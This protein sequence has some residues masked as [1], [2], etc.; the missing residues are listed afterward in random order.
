MTSAAPPNAS[1]EPISKPRAFE[2]ARK[3]LSE[4]K[5]GTEFVILDD[6]VVEKDFGWVF[7]YTT[8]AY[9]ETQDPRTL[10][11]GAGPLVVER[12]GGGTRFLST[13]VPPA[14]AIEEFEKTWREQQG[15]KKN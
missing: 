1:K 13:S 9:L 11:P 10:V 15:R 7:L 14:K 4:L 2:V 12:Q 3:A 8:R 6:K 5:P